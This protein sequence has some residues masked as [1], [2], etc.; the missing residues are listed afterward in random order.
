MTELR[1]S[2]S[3]ERLHHSKTKVLKAFGALSLGK[4]KIALCLRHGALKDHAI[5]QHHCLFIL[6]SEVKDSIL[7]STG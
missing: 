1:S 4:V 6:K 2:F 7:C 5:K 3:H